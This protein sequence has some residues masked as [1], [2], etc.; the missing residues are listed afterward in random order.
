MF[1][2]VIMI[3]ITIIIQLL[4][5]LLYSNVFSEIKGGKHLVQTPQKSIPLILWCKFNPHDKQIIAQLLLLKI[6]SISRKSI[7]TEFGENAAL[8]LKFRRSLA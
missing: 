4:L 2:F 3:M 8:T 1:H 7:T 6:N 5:L